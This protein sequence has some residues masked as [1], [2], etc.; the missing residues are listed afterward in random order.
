LQHVGFTGFERLKTD[1]FVD[2]FARVGV[3]VLLFGVGLEI[4]RR[5]NAEV[6]SSSLLVARSRRPR[7]FGPRLG[8]RARGSRRRRQLRARFF[9]ATLCATS[10]GTVRAF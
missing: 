7:P 3:L 8:R 1:P 5:S 10:V 9:G 4:D 6:G 2:M